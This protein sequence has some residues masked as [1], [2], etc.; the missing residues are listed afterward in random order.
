MLSPTRLRSAAKMRRCSL[1]GPSALSPTTYMMPAPTRP[2]RVSNN[3]ATSSPWSMAVRAQP[4]S[5][6]RAYTAKTLR[7]S[8]THVKN[9]AALLFSPITKMWS[10]MTEPIRSERNVSPCSHVLTTVPRIYAK[11]FW[12]HGACREESTVD[13]C[14]SPRRGAG[15][16]LNPGASLNRYSIPETSIGGA[17]VTGGAGRGSTGGACGTGVTYYEDFP[18]IDDNIAASEVAWAFSSGSEDEL[19]DFEAADGGT[20]AGCSLAACW[21]TL[22]YISILH[23]LR[24]SN[25][26]VTLSP[27]RPSPQHNS[28]QGRIPD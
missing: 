23:S 7:F 28:S 10:P 16:S 8:R 4:T 14:S 19:I 11:K 12:W 5:S 1:N 17:S 21:G 3:Q 18:C 6:I 24:F 26:E 22:R 2:V 13:L 27:P 20:N 15:T 25:S 9:N